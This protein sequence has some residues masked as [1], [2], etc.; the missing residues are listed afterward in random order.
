[1]KN[2]RILA[3][4][5]LS[6]YLLPF[7]VYAADNS[8][9]GTSYFT[10]ESFTQMRDTYI[11][12]FNNG[13]PGAIYDLYTIILGRNCSRDQLVEIL[14][15]GYLTEY[16]DEFKRAQILESDYTLPDDVVVIATPELPNSIA[17]EERLDT[18]DSQ[19]EYTHDVSEITS[20]QAQ[21]VM[22]NLLEDNVKNNAYIR[23]PVSCESK[24]LNGQM[25]EISALAGE[26]LYIQFY[27]EDQIKYT[28][29]FA[30]NLYL[31][32][33]ELNLNIDYDGKALD[34]DLGDT[35]PK[36]AKLYIHT[37]EPKDTVIN[38]KTN[39]G[40]IAYSVTVD[41]DGFIEIP[42]IYNSG[43][44]NIS[45]AEVEKAD[46]QDTNADISE[47]KQIQELPE[48]SNIPAVVMILI[49]IIIGL[50]STILLIQKAR[51]Q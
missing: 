14:E 36:P 16:I 37:D 7:G 6:I 15:M 17:T 23:C 19:I 25:L 12:R 10:E 18:E 28:W 20:V 3:A 50:I 40:N 13:E 22:V 24:M 46:V 33:Q 32:R 4:V 43:H 27:E 1:M 31:K 35:L 2:I 5:I 49:F 11:E 29:R 39:D 8:T 34:F 51:Q 30:A 47:E 38:L 45:R 44:Y 26:P 21:Q 41:A 48:Y 42:D 9:Q